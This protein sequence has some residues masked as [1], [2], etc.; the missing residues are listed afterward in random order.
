[1]RTVNRQ[2]LTVCFPALGM[3]RD[4]A[5]DKFCG[6]V[7]V[8]EASQLK[9]FVDEGLAEFA[10]VSADNRP[11]YGFWF[12][13]DLTGK[14]F[15]VQAAVSLAEKFQEPPNFE[16]LI[17]AIEAVAMN[18]NCKFVRFQTARLGLIDL[19]KKFGYQPNAVCLTKELSTFAKATEDK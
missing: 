16:D 5:A 11:V 19:T 18:R 2:N 13:I 6:L 4:E 15:N 8:I 17:Q 12:Q 3:E 1:M 7:P 14:A 10:V 9:R